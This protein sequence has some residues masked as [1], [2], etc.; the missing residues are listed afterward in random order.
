MTYNQ[1]IIT[2]KRET[3]LKWIKGVLKTDTDGIVKR[4]S[5]QTVLSLYCANFNVYGCGYGPGYEV[6]EGD[7]W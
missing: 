1:S 2:G 4:Q 3:C 5:M 7:K 6:R